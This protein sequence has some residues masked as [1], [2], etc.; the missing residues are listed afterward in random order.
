MYR[1]NIDRIIGDCLTPT[2]PLRFALLRFPSRR[3]APRATPAAVA[4]SISFSHSSGVL[5]LR[6]S[7]C[8]PI[9]SNSSL[10]KVLT[11]R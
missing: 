9:V 6:L 1:W 7:A 3:Y 5:S 10:S 11:I 2:A 4:A 8:R